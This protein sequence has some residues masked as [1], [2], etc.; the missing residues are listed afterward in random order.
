MTNL[1]E[2]RDY[3]SPKFL[4]IPV[5]L[6]SVALGLCNICPGVVGN[7]HDDGIYVVTAKAMATGQGYRLISLPNPWPQTKYPVLYPFLLSLIWRVYPHF[8]DNVLP[9]KLLSLASALGFLL[10]SYRFLTRF[11]YT[12]PAMA[13]GIIAMAAWW[14]WTVYFSSMVLSEMPYAFLSVLALYVIEGALR[15]PTERSRNLWI[16]AAATLSALA[17]L[18]RTVGLLLIVGAIIFLLW[19]QQW[20]RSLRFAFVS[21]IIITPWVA[22]TYLVAPPQGLSPMELYYVSY[23]HWVSDYLGG[24]LSTATLNVFC[25][26]LFY[27]L[28][29]IIALSNPVFVYVPLPVNFTVHAGIMAALVMAGLGL[30]ALLALALLRY[31]R[32]QLRLLDIYMALYMASVLVWPWSPLR[33]LV[34]VAPF[35]LLYYS[36]LMELVT[37]RVIARL[38]GWRWQRLARALV[39]GFAASGLVLNLAFSVVIVRETMTYGFQL[40]PTAKS[41]GGTWDSSSGAAMRWIAAHTPAEATL[42]GVF[43]PMVYLYTGRHAVRGFA[44]NPV[45]SFYAATPSRRSISEPEEVVDNWRRFNVSYVVLIPDAE[46]L[47]SRY[48]KNMLVRHPQWLSLSYMSPTESV[49]IFQIHQAALRR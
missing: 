13:I 36:R 37:E 29:G 18:T 17:Y 8:P 33:F 15:R 1:A 42:S 2:P 16:T 6:V 38:A 48:L 22:W 25:K 43:D 30:G 20:R 12:A 44:I 21:L 14:P 19:H 28:S 47:L 9:M 40:P 27:C 45:E 10:I 3:R 31:F 35:L 39:I 46:P 49:I 4:L 24:Y 11:H 32:Y 23:T 5:L 41:P 26:N 7:Y 34:P